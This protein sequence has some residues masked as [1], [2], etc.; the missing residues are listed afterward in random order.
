MA[1]KI[2]EE[3]ARSTILESRKGG[4]CSPDVA[5]DAGDAGV[6]P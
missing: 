6:D 1:S 5:G 4:T 2:F 3:Y